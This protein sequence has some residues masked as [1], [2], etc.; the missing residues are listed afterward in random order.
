MNVPVSTPAVNG[1]AAEA[2][3]SRDP[4]RPQHFR[5]VV[6]YTVFRAAVAL[7]AAL[8]RTW[9]LRLGACLGDVFYVLDRRDRRVALENLR[10]AFPE[11]CAAEHRRILRVSCRNLGR[12]GAE[13][14][15]LPSLD[16]AALRRV[17]ELDDADRAT[18]ERVFNSGRGAVI[19]SGHVGNWELLAY[20]F[21]LLGY[22]V[23]LV[24][25]PMHNARVDAFVSAL[26][27]RPGTRNIPKKSAAKEVIRTLKRGGI[28]V[29]PSDQNQT[30]SFGVFVNFF[31]K[32]ACT[33]PGAARLAMLTGA[34]VYPVFLVRDGETGRHH[35]E[36]LPEVPMVDTGD[37]EADIVANTQRCSD[38]IEAMIRRYPEQWI[39][40]HKR[41]KTRPAGETRRA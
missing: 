19:V 14:C 16:A 40:F 25:R 29:I 2:A 11:K 7:F 26:R 33:S 24:H 6:E 9:A 41:W 1:G 8:P 30:R 3:I 27:T 12:V 23:T 17:V 10:L 5:H 36:V 37:R 4:V 28:V 31:G 13:F 38:A 39:W 20:A 32:A 15:H 34:P 22:P 18:A 35:V 21:A